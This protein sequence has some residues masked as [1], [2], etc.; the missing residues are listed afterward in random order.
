MLKHENSTQS[1]QGGRVKPKV[2]VGVI[3]GGLMGKEVASAFG[4]WFTLDAMPVVP[5]LLGVADLNPQALEWFEQVPDCRQLTTRYEELLA[6]PE[7]E[8]IYA[9]VPHS[10]HEEIYGA[11][12]DAG[13]DL[14][15]EKPFGIASGAAKRIAE[16]ARKLGR[17]VRC[18][19]EMPFWP[20]ARRAWEMIHS[21]ALGEIIEVRTGLLHASDLDRNKP[22][23]WKRQTALCG[24]A[25]VMADLG[26][27]A[28]HLPLRLGWDPER[29]YAQLTKIVTERPDGKGGKAACDTWD[30]AVLH[31]TARIDG[32]PVPMML[33]MK[34]IAPGETNTWYFEVAGMNSSLRFSTKEPKTFWTFHR[35]GKSQRW[36]REDLG[37]GTW[38]PT[39]TGAIWEPGMPDI[40]AQM[41]AAYFTERNGTLDGRFH[42]ATPEEAVRTHEIFEAALQ[43]HHQQTVVNLPQS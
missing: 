17:F 8:V 14:F 32:K 40:L 4:R 26:M 36:C 25:G 33:E 43:S 30:N 12:L 28:L 9:A 20:A 35:E 27:H 13:K 2:G 3:G 19:S 1:Y 38:Y 29:L 34:R 39:I 21:G 24:P 5:R 6:N 10:L 18:S 15:A 42:C 41:W 11:V 7:I 31:S 23:N 22:L 37:F 16:K